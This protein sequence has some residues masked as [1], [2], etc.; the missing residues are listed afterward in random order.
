M[1]ISI[2]GESCTGKLTL[3]S[4][5]KEI[6]GLD[7]LV[8]SG[9]D[10][11]RLARNAAEAANKYKSILKSNIDTKLVIIVMVA[12]MQQLEFIP[13]QAFNILMIEELDVIKARFRNR[14]NCDLPQ[15]VSLMLERKHHMFDNVACNLL[16]NHGDKSIDEVLEEIN[17][18]FGKE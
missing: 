15:P 11:L 6:Y 2:I 18:Y 1:I 5:L 9:N 4:K 12:E 8:F 7:T 13:T 16:I 10:Y 17:S 14:L 3:A